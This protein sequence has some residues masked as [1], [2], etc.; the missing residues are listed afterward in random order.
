M[1]NVIAIA[2]LF[3]L[4][5]IGDADCRARVVVRQQVVAVET[6]VIPVAVY[7]PVQVPLYTASYSGYTAYSEAAL[8]QRFDALIQRFDAL[9]TRLDALAAKPAQKPAAGN[10]HPGAAYL[11]KSCISCH[12]SAAA[13]MKGG[14]HVYFDL[15]QLV[16]TPEQQWAIS[17]AI[18]QGTMPKSG[19]KAQ[20]NDYQ[21]VLEFFE[22]IAAQKAAKAEKIPQMPQAK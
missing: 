4:C 19:P 20:D 9:T 10:I 3:G 6:P 11:G 5:S 18:R 13:K 15:G 2:A 8:A 21:N 12:D 17:R 16:A 7:Q 1:K 14:G 22:E